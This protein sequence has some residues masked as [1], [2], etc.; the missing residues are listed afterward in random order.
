MSLL[1]DGMLADIVKHLE[2][3]RDSSLLDIGCGRGFL[4]RWLEKHGHFVHVVGIDRAPEAIGAAKA[5]V[6]NAVFIESDY[7]T[8]RFNKQFDA[9]LALEITVSGAVDETLVSTARAALRDGGRFSITVASLNGK[10]EERLNDARRRL[11]AHFSEVEF[12]DATK[13][14][15]DFAK[16]LYGALVEIKGWNPT[17][18]QQVHAQAREVLDSIGRGDFNY[19]VAFARA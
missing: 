7:R 5:N 19:A 6:P 3:S 11:G 8:H 13:D 10:H 4:E 14:A 12:L 18:E 9:A 15:S 2:I 17:I 16:H 1:S